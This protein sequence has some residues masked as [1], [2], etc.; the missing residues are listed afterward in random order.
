MRHFSPEE[1]KHL[2]GLCGG[3]ALLLF[4]ALFI[5]QGG[6]EQTGRGVALFNAGTQNAAATALGDAQGV[7]PGYTGQTYPDDQTCWVVYD[8]KYPYNTSPQ[9]RGGS[10]NEYLNFYSGIFSI[11]AATTPSAGQSVYINSSWLPTGFKQGP[12]LGFLFDVLGC[13]S[14]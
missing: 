3:A 13:P 10:S 8:G 6:L 4:A 2:A 7:P 12:Q 11:N 9:C 1:L 14:G 5:S